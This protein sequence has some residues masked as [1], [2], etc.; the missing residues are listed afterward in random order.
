MCGR[1]T[2]KAKAAEFS[3][4]V[5]G[6]KPENDLMLTNIKPTQNVS[7]V[8]LDGD[9][10]QTTAARWW[11]QKEGAK[12]FKTDY[13][14]FN[15]RSEKVSESFLFRNALKSK[16]CL[17]PATSFYEWSE[18]GKPP[19]EIFLEAKHPFAF[20]GL[21]STYSEIGEQRHSF[22]I[23][24][25]EPNDFMKPIHNRMPVILDS[26]ELQRLWLTEGSTQLLVPFR[27]QLESFR[28]SESIEKTYPQNSISE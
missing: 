13:T 27:N 14:T 19:H 8:V 5:Y 23:I 26:I 7:I 11:F 24:T 15:A 22:T 12:E 10:P 25:C 6:F 28:L 21:W 18:K 20:A 3:E 9:Q 2:Q 4:F 17:V 16:R 1:I